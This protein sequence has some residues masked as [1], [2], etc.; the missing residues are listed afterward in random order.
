MWSY[1]LLTGNHVVPVSEM[2]KSTTYSASLEILVYPL[3]CCPQALAL[4][5]RYQGK[6]VT[7]SRGWFGQLWF[8]PCF[9]CW[10]R[11]CMLRNEVILHRFFWV[12]ASKWS[13]RSPPSIW[14]SRR[15]SPA[16][17]QWSSHMP[18]VLLSP[19]TACRILSL[20]TALLVMLRI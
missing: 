5:L 11:G 12:I 13:K 19:I 17:M 16:V 1:L 15:M 14:L 2:Q 18:A 4:W 3:P 20:V 6:T 8:C 7:F 9:E 10:V